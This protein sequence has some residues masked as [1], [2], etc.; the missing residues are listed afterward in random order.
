MTLEDN[1]GVEGTLP[2]GLRRFRELKSTVFRRGGEGW[3]ESGGEEE[4][5]TGPADLEE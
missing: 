5:A 2:E 3:W 4:R 1:S